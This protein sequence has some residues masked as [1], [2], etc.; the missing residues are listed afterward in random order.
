MRLR[1][2]PACPIPSAKIGVMTRRA[3]VVLGGIAVTVACGG[4]TTGRTSGLEGGS[5]DTGERMSDSPARDAPAVLDSGGDSGRDAPMRT[6]CESQGAMCA[7]S[8]SLCPVELPYFC[9][10]LPE[11]GGP[12]LICCTG[13][14]D[15]ASPDGSSG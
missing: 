10:D 2:T 8:G 7:P 5:H 14:N 11:G 6:L 1:A 13:F 4:Q 9:G 15:A 3:G 12:S